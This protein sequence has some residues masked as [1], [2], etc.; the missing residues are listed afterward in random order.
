[1]TLI[2]LW[3][4]FLCTVCTGWVSSIPVSMSGISVKNSWP[5]CSPGHRLHITVK[6]RATVVKMKGRSGGKDHINDTECGRYFRE[7]AQMGV[8]GGVVYH[9]WPRIGGQ[10]NSSSSLPPPHFIHPLLELLFWP[11][12]QVQKWHINSAP[13][14]TPQKMGGGWFCLPAHV[15]FRQTN[16]AD[17]ANI[18][19]FICELWPFHRWITNFYQCIINIEVQ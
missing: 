3:D 16:S 17:S 15:C 14:P 4:H 11:T 9:F 10:N 2:F 18:G 6:H 5:N 7:S 1:M 19:C 8:G 13:H 12:I